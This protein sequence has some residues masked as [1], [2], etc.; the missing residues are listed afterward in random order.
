MM[1]AAKTSPL[2]LAELGNNR[3]MAKAVVDFL[4]YAGTDAPQDIF[5]AALG[6]LHAI[7]DDTEDLL[8]QAFHFEDSLGASRLPQRPEKPLTPKEALEAF[9][10][11][12]DIMQ[13]EVE[14]LLRK[15][16]ATDEEYKR[17]ARRR[18]HVIQM[19][20][21]FARY[22]KAVIVSRDPGTWTPEIEK[23]FEK[24]LNIKP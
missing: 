24:F 22:Y 16:W 12:L 11:T 3:T 6:D 9:Q 15:P 7:L 13:I 4:I 23:R 2:V 10:T 14:A 21:H 20:G 8:R 5:R 17:I 19:M 1:S 18:D